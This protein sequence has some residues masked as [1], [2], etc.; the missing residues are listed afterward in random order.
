MQGPVAGMVP[1]FQVLQADPI[2]SGYAVECVAGFD[3]DTDGDVVM[4]NAI[5]VAVGDFYGLGGRLVSG[6]FTRLDGNIGGFCRAC[7]LIAQGDDQRVCAGQLAFMAEMDG[8]VFHQP[9]DADVEFSGDRSD[10][11]A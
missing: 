8:I 7:D 5:G 11:F 3:F 2:V 1:F 4:R 9:G 10:P 6:E